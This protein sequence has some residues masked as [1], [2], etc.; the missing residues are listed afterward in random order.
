MGVMAL[1]TVLR[2]WTIGRGLPYSVGADEPDIMIRVLHMLHEG[3]FNPHEFFDYPTLT[4]YMQMAVASARFITG[5]VRGEWI[6]LDQI[7]P[8]NFYLWARTF[9][10]LLSV[11]TVY[12]TYRAARRWT[13][14]TAIIA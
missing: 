3:D 2:F 14:L 13:P 1:A 10:A 11:G 12:V 8:G 7:W 5:A 6:T 9:T 4:F